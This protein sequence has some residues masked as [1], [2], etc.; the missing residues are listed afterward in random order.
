MDIILLNPTGGVVR[1]TDSW[2]SGC[3]G[4]IRD[5]GSRV[6][7]G[8]D[9]E[10]M[11]GQ[12]VVSPYDGKITRFPRPYGDGGAGDRG[13]EIVIPKIDR[14]IKLFYVAHIPKLE[15]TFVKRGD[16]IGRLLSLEARYP[17]ITPH[18]HVEL[19]QEDFRV[20]PIFTEV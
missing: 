3:Y 14:R 10:G 15:M 16:R 20:E 5:G 8:V 9:L 13:I 2:G 1:G 7:R 6:H 17:G 4:A 11:V 18:V 12:W 19:W